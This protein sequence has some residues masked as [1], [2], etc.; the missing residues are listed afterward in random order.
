MSAVGSSI[1]RRQFLVAG[2]TLTGGLILGVPR[3][4]SAG[5]AGRKIGFFVPLEPDGR[6]IIGSNQPEI[7]QGVRTALPMLVAEELDVEW[8]AVSI[9]QMPLGIVKIDDGYTWKAGPQGVGGSTGLTGN[10]DYMR[11]VGATA[12]G[13]LLAAAAQRL[14]V[15][16]AACTTRPGFVVCESKSTE[17]AYSVVTRIE[18]GVAISSSGMPAALVAFL[19]CQSEL[20]SRF[21][22][23]S[24]DSSDQNRPAS[25]SRVWGRSRCTIR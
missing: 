13:Q 17:I 7:G 12:R 8:S 16:P 22:A 25:R 1:N 23:R 14:G 2:A 15:E 4:S 21:R 20:L 9:R 5:A 6:V 3:L 24:S 10:W 19:I 18:L 11:Q